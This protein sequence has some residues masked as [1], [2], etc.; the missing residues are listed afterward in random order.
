MNR[1]IVTLAL[2][3]C[4]TGIVGCER[5]ERTVSG[6]SCS[7]GAQSCSCRETNPNDVTE[8]CGP[9]PCCFES[10]V[11]W[12]PHAASQYRAS[13][14]C[15]ESDGGACKFPGGDNRSLTKRCP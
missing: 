5:K 15:Y 11:P 6:W 14:E 1:K 3:A 9:M 4:W 2:F 10:S 7:Y 12:E 13:C 8:G